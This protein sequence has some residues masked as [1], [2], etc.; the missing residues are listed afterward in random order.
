M[1]LCIKNRSK[2]NIILD[3]DTS[4]D[5]LMAILYLLAQPDVDI[6]AITIVHGV[7]DVEKGT[8]IVLQVTGAYRTC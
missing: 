1:I 4:G 8:E 6:K 7:S 3:V 2:R 5:D